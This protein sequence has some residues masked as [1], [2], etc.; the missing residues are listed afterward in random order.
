MS[1]PD[2]RQLFVQCLLSSCSMYL[3]PTRHLPLCVLHRHQAPLVEF[4]TKSDGEQVSPSKHHTHHNKY[5]F[6]LGRRHV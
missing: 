6:R 1:K 2:C 4:R 3:F 5:R